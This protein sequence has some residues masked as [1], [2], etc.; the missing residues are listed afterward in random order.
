MAK[1]KEFKSDFVDAAGI[2]GLEPLLFEWISACK[3]YIHQMKNEDCPFQ[4]NEVAMTGFLAGAAWRRKGVALQEYRTS[5]GRLLQDRWTGRCDL[6]VYIKP[7][8]FIFESKFYR[9]NIGV[10]NKNSLRIIRSRLK[11]SALDAKQHQGFKGHRLGICFVCPFYGKK[12][13]D[14]FEPSLPEWCAHIRDNTRPSAIAWTFPPEA[15]D[16]RGEWNHIFPGVVAL[17]R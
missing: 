6:Y 10:S 4:Y 17:L 3:E 13:R 16:L 15:R 7:H 11:Q 12:R 1:A 14:T 2:E 8:E 5:K 9:T